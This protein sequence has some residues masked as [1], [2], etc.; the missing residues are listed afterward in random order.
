MAIV[1]NGTTGISGINALSGVTSIAGTNATVT[2]ITSIGSNSANTPVILQDSGS[3]SNVLRAWVN[4][5]GNGSTSINSSFNVSSVTFNST[6]DYTIN[7]TNALPDANY[8]PIGTGPSNSNTVAGGL[9]L[10]LKCSSPTA[11]PA[12]KSTTQ[13]G[14]IFAGTGSN[15]NANNLSVVFFR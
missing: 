10:V 9:G 13:C 4:F 7:F 8:L 15:V 2:G 12:L 1:I 14:M 3:N 11:S 6:G 5:S